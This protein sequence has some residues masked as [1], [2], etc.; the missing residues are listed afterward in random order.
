MKQKSH[1]CL[2]VFPSKPVGGEGESQEGEEEEEEGEG[3]EDQ[4]SGME[5]FIF[6][7][8]I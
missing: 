5:S 3:G 6:G 1:F 8:L 2:K 7:F 4:K